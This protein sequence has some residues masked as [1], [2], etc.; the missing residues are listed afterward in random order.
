M[1]IKKYL[2][3]FFLIKL[4]LIS[5][6][7]L[8]M[9]AVFPLRALADSAMLEPRDTIMAR[10]E[11]EILSLVPKNYFLDVALIRN[12]LKGYTTESGRFVNYTAED[13]Q[14]IYDDCVELQKTTFLGVRKERDYVTTAGAPGAGKS[15]LLDRYIAQKG[16]ALIDPDEGSLRGMKSSFIYDVVH[17]IVPKD[18]YYKWRPASNFIANVLLAYAFENGYAIAHGSTM[19]SPYSKCEFQAA[20]KYGYNRRILHLTC[21]D[22]L[23]Q[24]SEQHRRQKKVYEDPI[25]FHCTDE[26]L[27]SKGKAFYERLPDYMDPLNAEEVVFYL[28]MD[29]TTVLEVARRSKEVVEIYYEQAFG[30]IRKA[31]DEAMG[32]GYFDRCVK[33]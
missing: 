32:G 33:G 14:R 2:M 7:V 28:R 24:A 1:K 3:R 12:L 26:D 13:L 20:G 17:E 23:R 15:T 22:D 27:V 18:A 25:P 8:T 30:A 16:Y 5:T 11:S 29:M 21:S 10:F 9:A 6:G 19:T 31:H 4:F